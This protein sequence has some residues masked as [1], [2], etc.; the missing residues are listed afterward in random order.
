MFTYYSSLCSS[1]EHTILLC[2]YSS[3][4]VLAQLQVQGQ[5][6]VLCNMY[7]F[8]SL[9]NIIMYII[10]RG[11]KMSAHVLLNLLN[12]LGKSDKM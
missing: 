4:F 12:E 5:S 7:L 11:S 9:S 2:C 1:P 3:D 8:S 10:Y 6:Q